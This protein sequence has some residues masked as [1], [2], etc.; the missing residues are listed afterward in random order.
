MKGNASTSLMKTLISKK[1]SNCG[2]NLLISKNQQHQQQQQSNTPLSPTNELSSS[3]N[4]S[5]N[6]LTTS[7]S[8]KIHQKSSGSKTP[9]QSNYEQQQA[10]SNTTPT[11]LL[12]Q[13]ISS[14]SNSDSSPSKLLSISTNSNQGSPSSSS[15]MGTRFAITMLGLTGNPNKSDQ[16]LFQK[17]PRQSEMG[18]CK[19]HEEFNTSQTSKS[20]KTKIKIKIPFKLGDY[21]LI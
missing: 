11:S 10:T 7:T 1:P 2:S 20:G 17:L 9:S 16:N 3:C 19:N 5:P 6:A 13:S 14:S 8:S 12:H 15:P 4:T 21:F 18:I